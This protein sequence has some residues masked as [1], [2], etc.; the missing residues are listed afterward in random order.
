MALD[1]SIG[2]PFQRLV[3]LTS[4]G[5]DKFPCA[6]RRYDRAEKSIDIAHIYAPRTLQCLRLEM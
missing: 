5:L 2:K 1:D 3:Q 6:F 4:V